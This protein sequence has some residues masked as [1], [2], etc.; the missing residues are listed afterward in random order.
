MVEDDGVG[1]APERLANLLGGEKGSVGL[2]NVHRRLINAYGPENGLNLES[3]V[4]EGT[5][6][7]MTI[8]CV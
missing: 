7:W 8:P 1:I 3:R 5:K 6:I 4:G 2:T